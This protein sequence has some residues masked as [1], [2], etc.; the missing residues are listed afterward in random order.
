M[1][2]DNEGQVLKRVGRWFQTKVGNAGIGQVWVRL[3]N[4]R[5]TPDQRLSLMVAT[6][7][8]FRGRLSVLDDA[9]AD[10]PD[11]FAEQQI[12]AERLMPHGQRLTG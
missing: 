8:S 3:S 1:P 11:E 7:P 6:H 12:L 4:V 2:A 5:M 9:M 10:Q